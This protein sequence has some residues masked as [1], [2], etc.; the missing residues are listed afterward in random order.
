MGF[1]MLALI[2]YS[3]SVIRTL[4]EAAE[5]LR[6]EGYEVE[7]RAATPK[8]QIDW[9][10][11]F[12]YAQNADAL[13]IYTSPSFEG[14][15]RLLEG[16][17]GKLIISL[18]EGLTES[19]VS[20]EKVMEAER[21]YKY[22]G[23][24]NLK[25]LIL[26]MG[27]LAG[28]DFHP[29]PPEAVPWQGIYHPKLGTFTSTQEYRSK[30]HLKPRIGIL[31][32]R[33][34]WENGDTA[35]VDRLIERFES[36]GMG[37]MAVFS[38]SMGDERLGIPGNERALALFEGCDLIINL[39]SFFIT[40]KPVGGDAPLERLNVPVI[41]GVKEYYKTEEEWRADP[42][43]INPM[44]Q[45]MSVAQPEFDG[46]IEPILVSAK[47]EVQEL[48]V[49]GS[50]QVQ[51]PIEDRIELIVRRAKNWLAL[52]EKPVQERRVTFVLHNAPCKSVE[53]TVGRGAGLDTLESLVRIMRAMK[54]AGYRVEDIPQTGKELIDRI[55]ERKAISE[56]RWTTADEIAGKGGVLDFIEA[57]RYERWFNSLPEGAR[58]KM[59][60]SW[61][62]PPGEAMIYDGK[63]MITGLNFGNVNVIVQP[64]RGCAGA[65]CDGQVCKIL[66][67]PHLPPPHHW[68]ATYRWMA[69][70][71]DVIVHI[72]THGYLEFL[73]GKGV[74]LA[75][76]DFPEISISDKPHLYI[77]TVANPSEGIIAKRRS[78]ATLV[79]HL[80]PVMSPS[81]LYDELET[82][83]ELLRQ[84]EDARRMEDETRVSFLAE[85]ITETAEKANLFMEREYEDF[86]EFKEFLHSRLTLFR[87][88]LIRDGL[89]ILGEP[90]QGDALVDMLVSILRFDGDVP[91]IRRK[92]MEVQ[93]EDYEKALSD[94]MRGELLEEAT[95][96]SVK[97]VKLALEE[98][99]S[100]EL[101]Y[102]VLDVREPLV[103]P[104]LLEVIEYGLS[105]VPKIEAVSQEVPQLLRGMNGEYIEPGA[106]GSV[107][108]GRI[109][110]LPTG[111]NFYGVDPWRVPTR[112]AVKVGEQLAEKLLHRYIHEEGRY[113]ESVGMVLWSID[114]FRADGEEVA[115]ILHLLGTRPRW[116][117]S[118][119][120]RGVE[121]IP[122]EELR[123]PRIDVTV[124]LSG[125]M[126]DTLPHIWEMIDEAVQKVSSL[127]EPP[128]MNYIRKHKLEAMEMGMSEE[129]ATFRIFASPPGS[130]GTG[131]NYAV[132]ASAW[133]T[134]EDLR[135]VYVD[136][137]GYAYGKGVFGRPA[138][139]SFALNLQK[140]EVSFNKLESDEHDS[141]GC[142][143]YFGYQGGMTVA[144]KAM[145]GK[146][147][148]TYWG[149]THDPNHADVRDMKTEMER[150]VRTK[151]LNPKWLE[152]IKRHGY[153]GAGDIS[154]R[155][156]HLFGWDA[157]TGIVDDWVYDEVHR[158]IVM[159]MR[160]FFL[161][162]NLYAL[163]EIARRLL[164]AYQRGMWNADEE[165]IEE[166]KGIYLE[167]EGILEDEERT[168]EF[169]GGDVRVLTKEDV[170]E[171]REK[172]EKIEGWKRMILK[173]GG[174]SL[175]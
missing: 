68:L 102:R 111:R 96:K 76:E 127:D 33:S 122:I 131:V 5:S 9:E 103:V 69:E 169:Q 13:F 37:V 36:D 66:H 157:T 59:L 140:V 25:N 85:Q 30:Y 72:G 43:G 28:M 78:Y 77:Y 120:V 75:P 133:R 26:F 71:S 44:A 91:S 164:E 82:L 132:E 138:H 15:E 21:Y 63:L 41:Q 121:I 20:P 3:G 46:T 80:I 2:G 150:I 113:P 98:G 118:G 79:D 81:G 142:C 17:R 6:A 16:K 64:K 110:V 7:L 106:S 83:E 8:S 70:N 62:E 19:T 125:I 124:R 18:G 117:R 165:T 105:L 147:V 50:Y 65:K 67:D 171:W 130:Y 109:D 29:D 90:P 40:P 11:F 35:A 47:S 42:R 88:T 123:R 152:G 48:R 144:A 154:S 52:K 146:D 38:Y 112:A 170:A 159:G 10:E 31:F 115:Q 27:K 149:D 134:E 45:V 53:A 89:H 129:E 34:Q 136:W 73:P 162:H 167:I 57:E 92:V 55:M 148:K 143:C 93:G 108:R 4:A 163:E 84:Y 94:P 168:G 114:V 86:E 99:T 116:D 119:R 32:Y 151:L 166:L 100:Q 175:G 137:G 49:N 153:K 24:Q 14:L 128:E 12:S 58:E 56:F 95:R 61:G 160:D 174:K 126:R 139:S 101:V 39:Q 60:E 155:V 97:L 104:E 107:T 141:L 158:R 51:L 87:E 135:D 156:V 22:G 172:A 54:E 74:G 1:R 161:Q 173:G 145:S 23:V